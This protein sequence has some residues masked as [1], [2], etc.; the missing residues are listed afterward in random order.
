M[1]GGAQIVARVTAA[2][3][4][5]SPNIEVIRDGIFPPVGS[6]SSATQYDTFDGVNAAFEDWI[7]YTFPAAHLWEAVLFQEGR[8][9]WDGGWFDSLTVQVR[10]SGTWVPVTGLSIVPA[11][12]GFD[13]GLSYETFALSFVPISGDGIR[14]FGAP[15]GFADFISVGELSVFGDC[16]PPPPPASC[17]DGKM[18]TITLQLTAAP[19]G[20]GPYTVVVFT[21]K[22]N[23]L[24]TFT[25]SV[26][27]TFTVGT[28]GQKF[29][30]SSIELTFTGPAS[31]SGMKVHVSCSDDPVAGVTTHSQDGFTTLITTF[32]TVPKKKKK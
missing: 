3:G 18:A 1:T 26:G 30:K 21:D 20:P 25:V 24:G 14:I 19:A 7:G 6:G 8:H 2:T 4:G 5:G 15:G 31:T 23:P 12:P 22:N 9:F 13:N 29:E 16:Q 11:Y 27:D 17:E 28:P 32:T 10:Q